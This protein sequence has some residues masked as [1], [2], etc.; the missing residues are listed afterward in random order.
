M[1]GTPVI[2]G[3]GPLGAKDHSEDEYIEKPGF[4]SYNRPPPLFQGWGPY[5]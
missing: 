4:I 3:L 2:D 5:K 1:S